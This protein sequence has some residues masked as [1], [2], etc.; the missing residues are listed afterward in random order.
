ML[1]NRSQWGFFLRTLFAGR[2]EKSAPHLFWDVPFSQPAAH[3]ACK[4]AS[5]GLNYFLYERIPN[6]SGKNSRCNH[7]RMHYGK[8]LLRQY[9]L[10]YSN[11]RFTARR[12]H[13][14]PSAGQVLIGQDAF[15]K[16][17]ASCVTTTTYRGWL[18]RQEQRRVWCDIRKRPTAL[19]Y[20]RIVYSESSHSV[21]LRRSHVVNA[22][23]LGC[24]TSF[25]NEFA[26][27]LDG[28]PTKLACDCTRENQL[29]WSPSPPIPTKTQNFWKRGQIFGIIEIFTINVTLRLRFR[30]KNTPRPSQP[31]IYAAITAASRAVPFQDK[32]VSTPQFTK[33]STVKVVQNFVRMANFNHRFTSS[34]SLII[35]PLYKAL[36]GQPVE[37][38]C[39]EE[40]S[41]TFENMKGTLAYVTTLV[42]P[43]PYALTEVT[44]DASG[45]AASAAYRN[46]R[47]P[48]RKY[49]ALRVHCLTD[50]KPLSFAFA[51]ASDS[52][53]FRQQRH[54]A[55]ISGFASDVL[56]V[57]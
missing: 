18:K 40:T 33:V 52:W 48:K 7:M 16:M 28:L 31:L 21:N 14:L 45:T 24:L 20:Q 15:F 3:P 26:E 11:Y 35:Q 12:Q 51:R 50:H 55:Y 54:L 27:H 36:A 1:Q 29:I 41:A 8:S 42:Y 32:L 39:A 49:R 25:I 47:P 37:L 17:V 30:L 23:H 57:S 9:P 22:P 43:H 5:P 13:A 53:S 56:H 38:V 34:A 44:V 2:R 6:A 19:Q 46:P 10:P 4:R